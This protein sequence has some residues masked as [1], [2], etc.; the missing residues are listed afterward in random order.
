MTS[1]QSVQ[2]RFGLKIRNL[3]LAKNLSQEA[4]ADECA[5]DRSYIGGVER[6]E[7]NISIKNIEKV[8][9]ALNISI[10]EMMESI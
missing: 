10:S 5:L 4:F 3:R 8:A 9:L 6:G 1:S 7:R 2:K